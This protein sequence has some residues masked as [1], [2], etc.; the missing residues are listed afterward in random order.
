MEQARIAAVK[1][2]LAGEAVDRKVWFV[3][4]FWFF[5]YY[6][7]GLFKAVNGVANKLQ[8][9]NSSYSQLVISGMIRN[10]AMLFKVQI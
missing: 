7:D 2:L 9:I 6:S 1:L 4:G 3:A 10:F 5:F 8:V